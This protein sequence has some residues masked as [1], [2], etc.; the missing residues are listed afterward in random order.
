MLLRIAPIVFVILWAT[1]YIASKA[2][3]PYAEPFTLLAIRFALV[4]GVLMLAWPW[5]RSDKMRPGDVLVAV[6]IGG[7]VHGVTL[8]AVFWVIANEMPAGVVALIVCLQPLLVAALAGYVLGERITAMNWLGLGIGVIGVVLVLAPKMTVGSTGFSLAN[9][10][11]SVLALVSLTIGTVLQKIQAANVE[12]R[13]ALLPQYIGALIVVL[14]GSLSLETREVQWT[15]AF[16]GVMAW[17]VFVLSIGAISL[18]FMMIEANAVWRTAS[19]FYLV[20]PTTALMAWLL[21]NETL[22][23]VQGIG[24]VVVCA[25]IVLTNRQAKPA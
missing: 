12:F 17:L 11:V 5:L 2:G 13:K 24:F 10:L 22:T 6:V 18:L 7:L 14:I 16:I 25:A 8:A 21:F 3:A 9:V 23:V 4:V 1:G 15:P 19:L 20:P